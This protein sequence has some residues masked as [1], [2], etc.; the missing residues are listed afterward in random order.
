M[1]T[2]VTVTS[3]SGSLVYFKHNDQS[4]VASLLFCNCADV[5]ITIDNGQIV[6]TCPTHGSHVAAITPLTTPA[7]RREVDPVKAAPIFEWAQADAWRRVKQ[8]HIPTWGFSGIK[9]D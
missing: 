9:H 5:E 8:S 4:C 7:Q 6:Y 1:S 3:R 2:P